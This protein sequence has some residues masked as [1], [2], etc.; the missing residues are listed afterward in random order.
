MALCRVW[1]SVS[2]K[3]ERSASFSGLRGIGGAGRSDGATGREISNGESS[4][5]T[6]RGAALE[7]N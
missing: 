4:R 6:G 3:A 7:G 2:D 5:L 1:V